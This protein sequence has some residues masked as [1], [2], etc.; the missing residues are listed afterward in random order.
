MDRLTTSEFSIDPFETLNFGDSFVFVSET[1]ELT[2]TEID[3]SIHVL[4]MYMTDSHDD[5]FKA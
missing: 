4:L 1:R 2:P 3:K 5:Q